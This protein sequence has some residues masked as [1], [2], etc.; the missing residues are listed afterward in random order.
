MSTFKTLFN[1]LLILTSIYLCFQTI[2]LD[3]DLEHNFLNNQWNRD[4]LKSYR[5][6]QAE[7]KVGLKINTPDTQITTPADWSNVNSKTRRKREYLKQ[8]P[9]RPTKII[10]SLDSEDRYIQL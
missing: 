4:G 10:Q 5:I 8:K 1:E 2:F 3:F 9:F 7:Y 6:D